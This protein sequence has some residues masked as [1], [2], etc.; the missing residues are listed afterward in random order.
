MKEIFEE[1]EKII[2]KFENETKSFIEEL[3]GRKTNGTNR[4]NL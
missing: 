3:K 2:Q 4:K 1:M